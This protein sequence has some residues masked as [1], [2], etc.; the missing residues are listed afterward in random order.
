LKPADPSW[1]KKTSRLKKN[2]RATAA[3]EI[4]ELSFLDRSVTSAITRAETN[5]AKRMIH[6]LKFIR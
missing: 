3:T 4:Y 6:G 1:L 2:E 5:G